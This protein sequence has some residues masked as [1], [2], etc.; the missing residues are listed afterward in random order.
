MVRK[1][2]S[3]AVFCLI[4]LLVGI[5]LSLPFSIRVTSTGEKPPFLLALLLLITLF[6]SFIM[7]LYLSY[8]AWVDEA[9]ARKKLGSR[10]E[11]LAKQ[12]GL[13]RFLVVTNTT[14]LLWNARIVYPIV[15][16]FSSVGLFL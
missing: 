9:E 11:Q 4:V 15:A 12:Y 7:P 6:F 5:V 2:I 16:L 8:Q 10:A 1:Y 3:F 14:F 13:F